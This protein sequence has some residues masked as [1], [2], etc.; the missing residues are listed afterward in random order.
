MNGRVTIDGLRAREYLRVSKDPR[1]RSQSKG[2]QHAENLEV[3]PTLAYGKAYDD[4]GS[5]SEFQVRK[6]DDFDRLVGDLDADRFGAAVLVVWEISRGSRQVEEW[7]K[8]IRLLR[9]R[10][11]LVAVT[12][13]GRVYDPRDGGDHADLLAAAVDAQRSSYQTSVRVRRDVKASA[14]KGRPHGKIPYGYARRYDPTTGR[15]KQVVDQREAEVVRELF[16]RV[17]AGHSLKAISRDFTERGI[18]SRGSENVSPRP[19]LPTSLRW[20][21]NSPAYAGMRTH[22][23]GGR[24]GGAE[25][26]MIPGSWEALVPPDLWHKVRRILSD[27]ARRTSRNG[28]ALHLLSRIARC[29]ACD[30]WLGVGYRHGVRQYICQNGHT[31]CSADELDRIAEV[32]MLEYLAEPGAWTRRFA[33]DDDADTRAATLRVEVAEIQAALDDLADQVRRRKLSAAFASATEPGLRA[34]LDAAEARLAALSTPRELSDLI[35]PGADVVDRWM[36][37]ADN[38]PVRREIARLL[39]GPDGLAG[40]LRVDRCPGRRPTPTAERVSFDP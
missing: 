3:W 6:R 5:A 38:V 29:A 35:R 36:A 7:C 14:A 32:R 10:G 39:I 33:V 16:D 19:F 28:R 18:V 2:Q 40:S 8:L 24:R 11:V 21:A 15:S 1:Q 22:R 37:L 30:G 27:P 4:T 23:P 17:A 13:E 26:V 9:E 31:R 34:D 25:V 20:M 12:S